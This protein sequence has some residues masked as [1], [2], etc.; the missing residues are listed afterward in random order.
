M[1]NYNQGYRRYRRYYHNLRVLYKKP[2]VRDFTFLVLSLFT[3]SFFSF[4]A[5]KPSIKTIGELMKETKDK[6][7]ATEKLEQKINALSIA[8][9]EYTLI[10]P[11]LTTIYGVLPQKSNFSELA[12]QIEYLSQKNNITLLNL[13]VSQTS[14]LNEDSQSL[15]PLRFD[16]IAEGSY[17]NLKNFLVDLENLNRLVTTDSILISKKRGEGE[18]V[19]TTLSLKIS[20]QA[21][22]IQ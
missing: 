10:Q 19:E 1:I 2:P 3:V 17:K 15:I 9:K 14:P 18:V 11:E 13:R 21:Y 16:V 4:F 7:G 20:S 12:K 6:R 8:Q 5:I 22:Y